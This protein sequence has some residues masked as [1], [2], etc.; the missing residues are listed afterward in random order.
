MVLALTFHAHYWRFMHRNMKL[1]FPSMMVGEF[2]LTNG[3]TIS[4]KVKFLSVRHGY[5]IQ[6]ERVFL[7]Q[8]MEPF[9]INLSVLV[10]DMGT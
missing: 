4:H 6:L 1:G 9:F 7:L 2:L 5:L 10:S 3:G 8:R